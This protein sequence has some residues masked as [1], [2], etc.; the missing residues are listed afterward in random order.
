MCMHHNFISMCFKCLQ[1]DDETHFTLSP[2]TFDLDPGDQ[3]VIKVHTGVTSLIFQGVKIFKVTFHSDSTGE[4]THSIRILCSN[5]DV[6]ELSL[7]GRCELSSVGVAG[8]RPTASQREI[9]QWD[10][11]PPISVCNDDDVTP[12]HLVTDEKIVFDPVNP[13]QTGHCIVA[14]RNYWYVNTVC[15]SVFY[16]SMFDIYF[17]Q[18]HV[19][20]FLLSLYFTAYSLYPS[21]WAMDNS[22]YLRFAYACSVYEEEPYCQVTRGIA[23]FTPHGQGRGYCH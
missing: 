16:I 11:A 1:E 8:V 9:E 20:T 3:V 22:R 15:V 14:I 6:E 17:T 23:W 19:C 5:G 13:N 7:I 21:L 12:S 2:T 10:G 18:A 4:F